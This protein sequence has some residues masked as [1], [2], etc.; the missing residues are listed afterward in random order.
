VGALDEQ[1]R[2]VTDLSDEE[3]RVRVAVDA[4]DEGGDVDV[5]DVALD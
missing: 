4:T 3:R 1:T 5:A 2:L